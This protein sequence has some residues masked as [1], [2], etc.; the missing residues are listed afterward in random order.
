MEFWG[1]LSHTLPRQL[2][3]RR[4]SVSIPD[5]FFCMRAR[6]GFGLF[7]SM[8]CA[9]AKVGWKLGRGAG[10]LESSEKCRRAVVRLS[11]GAGKVRCRMQRIGSELHPSAR[12]RNA[13]RR[14]VLCLFHAKTPSAGLDTPRVTVA[15]QRVCETNDDETMSDDEM[16]CAL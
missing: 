8:R 2:Q 16:Y 10:E 12:N 9:G 13:R 1:K 14:I 4:Y 5:A 15:E 3:V 6:D 11:R 7:V